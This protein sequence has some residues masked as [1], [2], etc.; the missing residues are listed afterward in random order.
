MVLSFD[1]ELM[2][3]GP[4]KVFRQHAAIKWSTPKFYAAR[5]VAI[6]RSFGELHQTADFTLD[7]GNQ[8]IGN[9]AID[10]FYRP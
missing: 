10:E 3:R 2:L 9:P 1:F 6:S 5:G 8:R 7:S 4:G